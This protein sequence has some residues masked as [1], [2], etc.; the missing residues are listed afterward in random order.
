MKPPN[1]EMESIYPAYVGP[2]K[3]GKTLGQGQT[4]ELGDVTISV[5]H[6]RQDILI[7]SLC[8]AFMLLSNPMLCTGVEYLTFKHII[9]E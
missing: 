4:G 7:R 5:Y 2:Y 9:K 3:I 1:A 6:L 8:N